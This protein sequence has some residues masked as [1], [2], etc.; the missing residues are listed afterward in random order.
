VDKEAYKQRVERT[1]SSGNSRV[2]WQGIK[3]MASAPHIGRGETTADLGRYEGQNMA[4]ELNVFFSRFE[5]DI[6][7]SE[8]KQMEAPLQMFE[9]VVVF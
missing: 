1:L 5:S 3:T 8:V 2:A 7:V 4:N 9:R 6:F